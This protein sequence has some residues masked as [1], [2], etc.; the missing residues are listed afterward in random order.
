MKEGGGRKEALEDQFHCSHKQG[1]GWGWMREG[2]PE[3][4]YLKL[5][6]SFKVMGYNF[7]FYK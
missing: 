6:G 1:E 7:E 2:I 5:K 3:S 4:Q